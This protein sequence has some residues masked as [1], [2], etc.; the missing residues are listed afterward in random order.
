ML[1]FCLSARR[2]CGKGTGDRGRC[3][4]SSVRYGLRPDLDSEQELRPDSMTYAPGRTVPDLDVEQELR[5]I[6]GVTRT[7]GRT[8]PFPG[9]D[10]QS[11]MVGI[12][13]EL[14][15]GD[16]ILVLYIHR[17]LLQTVSVFLMKDKDRSLR[18]STSDLQFNHCIDLIH[19]L[20]GSLNRGDHLLVMK[21]IFIGQSHPFAVFQPFFKNRISS[22]L[23]VP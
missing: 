14:H 2:P 20:N 13:H 7:P 17:Q 22:Y 11:R 21:D 19:D 5:P 3:V 10:V 12:H 8:V 1:E 6:Q 4:A 16:G 15:R 9:L 18:H 23:K